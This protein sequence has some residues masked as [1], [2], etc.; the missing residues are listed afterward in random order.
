MKYKVQTPALK[1]NHDIYYICMFKYFL[2]LCDIAIWALL[3]SYQPFVYI[4][5]IRVNLYLTVRGNDSSTA[6][7]IGYDSDCVDFAVRIQ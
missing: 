3:G 6:G 7:A 2:C 1:N 4:F 5:Q